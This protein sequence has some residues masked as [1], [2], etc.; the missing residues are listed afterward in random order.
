M[1][2]GAYTKPPACRMDVHVPN[3]SVGPPRVNEPYV[4]LLRI[5]VRYVGAVLEIWQVG[6]A[7]ILLEHCF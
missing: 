7:E 4:G 2:S 6:Y 5:D 1:D 3:I